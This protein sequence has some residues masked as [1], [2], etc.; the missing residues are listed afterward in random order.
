[1]ADAK[2]EM[3]L[4]MVKPHAYDQRHP[5]CSHIL[6]YPKNNKF[7]SDGRRS[8]ELQLACD[9]TFMLDT[10]TAMAFYYVHRDRPFF[11]QLI[12]MIT[13]GPSYVGIIHGPEAIMNLRQIMGATNPKSAA[14]GTIRKKYGI[15]IDKNAVYGSDAPESAQWEIPFIYST[16]EIIRGGLGD[17]KKIKGKNHVRPKA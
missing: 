6:D 14:D 2:N 7:Y 13:E 5:I 1:M 12:R 4:F 8:V 3:T 15:D 16:A 11:L 9:K 17:S 10:D